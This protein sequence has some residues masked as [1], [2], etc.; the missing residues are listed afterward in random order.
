MDPLSVRDEL[1]SLPT[2]RETGGQQ[3]PPVRP[4][5]SVNGSSNSIRHVDPQH[6][7]SR[8]R[9]FA[10]F[11][12]ET[13]PFEMEM[14]SKSKDHDDGPFDRP[15]SPKWPEM[16]AGPSDYWRRSPSISDSQI[17]RPPEAAWRQASTQPWPSDLEDGPSDV[18]RSHDVQRSRELE[19]SREDVYGEEEDVD[20]RA[21]L[22]ARQEETRDM[23]GEGA[24]DE[25]SPSGPLNGTHGYHERGATSNARQ[26][27]LTLEYDDSDSIVLPRKVVSAVTP[28]SSSLSIAGAHDGPADRPTS[29]KRL[30]TSYIHPSISRLRSHHRT[31][32]TSTEQSVPGRPTSLLAQ[33]RLPSHFSQ[34]SLAKSDSTT[35]SPLPDPAAPGTAVPTDPSS[36]SS[37]P[38]PF[39]F[40]AFPFHPLRGISAHLFSPDA[41]SIVDPPPHSARKATSFLSKPPDPPRQPLPLGRPSVMDVRDIIA[42][43]TDGGLV[44]VYTFDQKLQHVLQNDASASSGPVTA[45]C[46][47][48]DGTYVGVGHATGNIHLYD[49][50]RPLKPARTTLGLTLTQVLSGQKEG[51]L[52]GSPIL[53]I[54]FVGAR[55][56]SIVTGDEHGRAFWW[57][58][59]KVIGV[60]SNDVVRMLGSYPGNPPAS[61]ET[62]GSV[63]TTKAKKQT[64]LFAVRPLPLGSAPDPSDEFNFTVLQTPAKLVIV[65]MKPKARTWYR[66]MRTDD[67]GTYGGLRG[68][69]EW[70][71][72]QGPDKVLAY[73]WGW[74]LRLLRIK[75]VTRV[76]K[77]KTV[78]AEAEPEFTEGLTYQ[79]TGPI[80]ALQWYDEHHLVLV[81]FDSI[82]LLDARTMTLV[83]WQPRK[84]HV[85]M[86]NSFY[87]SLNDGTPLPGYSRPVAASVRMFRGKLFILTRD[88]V[89][90]A[91]LLKWNDRILYRVHQGDFLDAIQIALA[92]YEDRPPG[93][94]ITLP[95]DREE[96][97]DLIG[98]RIRE[99]LKSSLDWAF[100]EDRMRDDT[101]YSVDGRGVDLTGLFEG[102]AS[103]CIDTSLALNDTAFL[104]DEEYDYFANAGIQNIFLKLLQPYIFQG[105]V[106]TIPPA[107]LK[108]LMSMHAEQEGDLDSAEAIIWHVEPTSLDINQVVTLCEA[109]GLWDALIHV[110]TR[111]MRDFVAPLV[112]LLGLMTSLQRDRM[113]RPAIVGQEHGASHDEIGA[114]HAYKLFAYLEMVLCGQS[115][116]SGEMLKPLEEASEAR[117]SVYDFI[118]SGQLVQWPSGNEGTLVPALD[119][120]VSYPYL[121]LILQF[122]TE[123]FL[124]AMDIAFEDPY[125]NDSTAAATSRQAIINIM[126]D[127]MKPDRFANEDITLLY[128]FVAR[129]LPKYPQFL[130][131]PPS[132]LRRLLVSLASETDL[133]NLE[134]R[135][136]ATEYLLST[137]TPD[138]IEEIYA[139]FEHAGFYRILRSMYRSEGKWRLLVLAHVNDPELDKCLFSDLD[140]LFDELKLDVQGMTEVRSGIE[141]VLSHLVDLNV[142]QTALL[143][144]KHFPIL[145]VQATETITSDLKKMA[146]LRSLLDRATE[147]EEEEEQEGFDGMHLDGPSTNLDSSM[148]LLYVSLLTRYDSS[149]VI[150]FLDRR[151]PAFFDLGALA[152]QCRKADH[153]EGQL[154][155]L[156][157]MGDSR[158]AFTVTETVLQSRAVDLGQAVIDREM[159]DVHLILQTLNS[160]SHMAV[161][162]CQEHSNDDN[163]SS[164]AQS[165]DLW[166]AV[167]H[168]VMEVVHSVGAVISLSLEEE[169][170]KNPDGQ[171]VMDNLRSLVQYTLQ[172][173]V[174]SSSTTTLSFPRMFKRLVDESSTGSSTQKGRAYSEFRT[175]LTGMLDSY[176][177]EGEMLSM[178]TRIVEEDLFW[179]VKEAT[180]KRQM[181]W[182]P[183]FGSCSTCGK[184]LMGA[185]DEQE[186]LLVL[187]SGEIKHKQCKA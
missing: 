184:G 30:S 180:K 90:V 116:P 8:M 154:W 40:S 161:R 103:T 98:S 164:A 166:F 93:N 173:L 10:R 44:L 158:A 167:L 187:A 17:G 102:L 3:R 106:R 39:N 45:V 185:A 142:R 58:L 138:H 49:L 76:S 126:L 105:K 73:S 146:Y 54:G 65:G 37:K 64:T 26:Q 27:D 183:A 67:G 2:E 28:S 7:V 109:H 171:M 80:V 11:D 46:V 115:Y 55:H 79:A 178:T 94:T 91:S 141:T 59:G 32:S 110:Y 20:E 157:K 174:A 113:S 78:K 176:R 14:D 160:V 124:H 165:E 84:T 36:S 97:R 35:A 70:C 71:I 104:F 16:E 139:L 186:S 57:S 18:W 128:I 179:S 12:S 31:A 83:E 119:H 74:T 89:E 145:H 15:A 120:G 66:K 69:A 48:P 81:T 87:E 1:E 125:L 86:S 77:T 61:S 75:I 52:Q 177:S 144:D 123:A 118:F 82:I 117:K 155:A 101:H 153:V 111:T 163:K 114:T 159:G 151:G 96:R 56:T 121:D 33:A 168:G 100:S 137:Y 4:L 129:N 140:R 130:F 148:R 63:V 156:D 19:G 41:K 150:A 172:S 43:G 24:V 38:R 9:A 85:L 135:Q 23:Y 53:H 92:Y 13:T 147:G 162:L 131:I 25:V 112:K 51:H 143:L 136:L 149:A 107:V 108:D 133:S 68:C 170:E 34:L 22:T 181:G 6:S 62:N 132:T 42:V 122:D 152:E 60:E 5:S 134:D 29:L 47:S 169:S 21:I 127:V 95:H 175:I 182:R 72:G 88:A 99:L 50:S